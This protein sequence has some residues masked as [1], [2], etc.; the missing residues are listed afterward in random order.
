MVLPLVPLNWMSLLMRSAPQV[1]TYPPSHMCHVYTLGSRMVD[2]ATR[3]RAQSQHG[4]Y[5]LPLCTRAWFS[6]PRLVGKIRFHLGAT[7]TDQWDLV[8]RLWSSKGIHWCTLVPESGSEACGAPSCVRSGERYLQFTWLALAVCKCSGDTH[9]LSVPRKRLALWAIQV[10]QGLEMSG[11]VKPWVLAQAQ[12]DPG[13]QGPYSTVR[14][15]HD[16]PKE[17]TKRVLAWAL[18]R[19]PRQRL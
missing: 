8:A 9:P 15:T 19:D 18:R 17:H 3:R 2:P 6:P 7:V 16:R 12:M 10:A 11:E 4:Q 5:C 13:P 1:R 14:N